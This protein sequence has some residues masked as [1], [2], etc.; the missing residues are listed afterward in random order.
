MHRRLHSI[1]L[2]PFLF[3]SLFS[4][5]EKD[6]SISA[7]SAVLMSP[8]MKR[9]VYSKNPNLRLSPASTTKIMT[10][11]VVLKNSS[12]DKEVTVSK[13]AASMEPS[14]VY[15]KKDEIY[16][17]GDLLKALLLNSGNDA[18]VALAENVA[19]S[20]EEFVEMMNKA[21]KGIG[22]KN[23]HFK[24]SNGL[25]AEGQYSTAY[26]LALIVREAMR[27]EEIVEI[28]KK[29]TDQIK[30]VRTGRVIKL[31]SHNKSLW[32][33]TPYKMLGKTGYTKKAGSCF[34]GYIDY[35]RWRRLIIVI[36]K[37]KTKW[38]DLGVLAEAAL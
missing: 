32:K 24:T 12:L 1:L 13:R 8:I 36:L 37:S 10:A 20:E 30:E 2:I 29:K 17:T 26:D 21:A 16:L 4:F 38:Q 23:T 31:R 35:N 25:P 34:A 5:S 11:I 9:I 18:S 3:L 28:M 6:V 27:H 33:D 19:G 15:I 7:E 14:K 22:A